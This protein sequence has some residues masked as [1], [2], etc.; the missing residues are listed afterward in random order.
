M[1]IVVCYGN[2]L[3]FVISLLMLS[4]KLRLHTLIETV[5]QKLYHAWLSN[6]TM[7]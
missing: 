3:L 1:A 6:L 7:Q 5:Q 2:L 4:S